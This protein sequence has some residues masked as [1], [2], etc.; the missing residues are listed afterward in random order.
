MKK[1]ISINISGIIFHIEEDGY[2]R[3]QHYLESINRY[4]RDMDPSGEIVSDIES[5]I[6]EIFLSRLNRE[7]QVITIEDVDDLVATMGNISDFKSMED[8][9]EVE[10]ETHQETTTDKEQPGSERDYIT[11]KLYRDGQRKLLG[12]VLAGMAHYF[13]TDPLWLRLTFII[14]AFGLFQFPSIGGIL[15]I[16]YVILWIIVPLHYNLPE[17]RS[18]RK[19]FRNPDDKV[20]GGVGSGVAAY[21]GVDPIA[22]RI[23]FVL[24]IFLGGSGV[25]LYIILWIILPEA[26]S[27]TDRVRM[28]GDP[29]TLSNIEASIKSSFKVKDGEETPLMKAILFPFRI[30]AQALD[31]L[32]R[33][34]GPIM[35]FL[36]EAIRV[37]FGIL[38][39]ISGISLAFTGMMTGGV[40]LSLF[41]NPEWFYVSDL[42]VNYIINEIPPYGAIGVVLMIIIP[43][44]F[45]IILGI[46]AVA[47][48]LMLKSSV[49]WTLFSLLIAGIVMTGAAAPEIIYGYQEDGAFEE[50]ESYNISADT[51]MLNLINPVDNEL[52]EPDLR[53]LSTEDS[54]F[55]LVKFYES[56][57]KN[58]EQAE[59]NAAGIQYDVEK[60]TDAIT[61]PGEFTLEDV[62]YRLQQLSLYLYIP[63]NQP[64]II[65]GS[66]YEILEY[67]GKF[68]RGSVFLYDSTGLRC[69]DCKGNTKNFE[70]YSEEYDDGYYYNFSGFDKIEAGDNF[71]IKWIQEDQYKIFVEG[72]DALQENIEI[73]KSGNILELELD[74]K[75]RRNDLK[76]RI[77]VMISAPQIN[78]IALSGVAQVTANGINQKTLKLELTGSSKANITANLQELDIYQSGVS[79]TEIKGVAKQLEGDFT[80]VTKLEGDLLQTEIANIKAAQNSRVTISVARELNAKVSGTASVRYKGNPELFIDESGTARVDRLK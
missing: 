7:K 5:R 49:G 64:F 8:Q 44:I 12:G 77:Q 37:A 14:L 75:R 32:G 70:G 68:R 22:I 66:L 13:K 58:R 31:W 45:L 6:A 26:K 39:V 36:V 41:S 24:L 34:L 56:R 46:S 4:F 63:Y 61:F 60:T 1:N 19:M 67:S 48:K 21:F 51:V 40:L 65:D 71:A 43:A 38:L 3:L 53:I 74:N 59:Y 62:P 57:G 55:K 10:E 30:I 50:A 54:V 18:S 52:F 78:E 23:V 17:E 76:G 25:L 73:S 33:A 2:S 20:L 47:K 9:A 69:L 16:G 28:K 35:N 11:H 42:P 80:G 79:S 15:F 72:D 27:I 29:V